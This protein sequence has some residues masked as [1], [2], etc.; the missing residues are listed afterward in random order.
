MKKEFFENKIEGFSKISKK[1]KIEWIESNYF[2]NKSTS[3]LEKYWNKDEAL[4]KIHDEFTE[5]TI[6]NFY[7]P[8][9]VAPN[10]LIDR[11]DYTIPMVIEESSVIAAACKAAKFW[12]NKGGFKTQ[13]L[14]FKKTGQV[15]FIFNGEKD[16]LFKFFNRLIFVSILI[17][18]F[19][20]SPLYF[21]VLLSTDWEQP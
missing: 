20:K 2:N 12:R 8:L 1:E 17:L 3:I 16:K 19:L 7:L 15:H 11:K 13:I 21:L 18:V 4:Q 6:S 9:G 14:N 5:N 10:F